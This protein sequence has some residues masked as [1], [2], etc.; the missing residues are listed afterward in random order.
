VNPPPAATLFQE[1]SQVLAHTHHEEPYDDFARQPLLPR[2]LSQAGPGVGWWDLNGDGH[3]DLLIGSGK[4]GSL[5]I[6]LGDGQGAFRRADNLLTAT[7]TP[8]DQTS[9]LGWSPAPGQTAILTGLANYEDGKA[10]G[11]AVSQFNWAANSSTNLVPADLSSAGPVLLGDVDGD[12]NLDLFVGGRVIAGRWPEPAT[13]RLYRNQGGKFVLDL[14]N[15]KQLEQV[16]LVS[17]AVFS[18]LDGDGYPE[19]L[20]A[21]EWG[22]IRIFHNDHG[23]FTP[24]NPKVTEKSNSSQPST[25][26]QLSGWWNGVT[27]GDLDGDG[28]L[29]LIASNWGLNSPYQATAQHPA[30]VYYGDLGGAGVVDIVEAEYE[31]ELNALAPRRYRDALTASLPF[32]A[33]RFATHKAYSEATLEAVLGEARARARV[34]EAT[35]L[36]IMAFLN[37]GDHFEVVPLPPEAQ[38][39]PA[40][41]IVVADFNGDGCQDVFLSQNFFATQPEIPRLDAGR[42]LLLL[43][44][45]QGGLRAV[46][47]HESG[48]K[49]YG[50][51]RGA[52]VADFDEDGRN[53]LVVTQNGGQTKL[54]HN[55]GAKPGLRVQLQGAPGNPR[56]IG[57]VVRLKFGQRFGAAQEL[58][59]GS[60]YLSQ[61]SSTVVLGTPKPPTAL[62]VRWPGGKVTETEIP[63]ETHEVVMD[64]NGLAKKVH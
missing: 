3:E 44:D 43:G 49:I 29:D 11:A 9:I 61:D 28:R 24:L 25:L 17:G 60:G 26:N 16:G 36:A 37:R 12:G 40:F 13:S 38:F 15:N 59:A 33:G 48:L 32:I 20:L 45:G 27:T 53:D 19:L 39:A 4:G 18:D 55:Q 51:Q 58:R 8:R 62:W 42:G 47:G 10:E 35:T 2:K 41:G 34:V 5:A 1:I 46:P 22:P 7:L 30:Q 23:Q 57:A 50:E 54:F 64:G 31:P 6:Y 21:C 63:A 56:G 14:D 52:A